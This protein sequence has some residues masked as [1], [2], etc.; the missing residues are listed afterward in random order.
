MELTDGTIKLRSPEEVDA[1]KVSAVVRSSLEDLFP[2]LPWATADY[3]VDE[4]G[5]WIRGEVDPTAQSFLIVEPDGAVVGAAALNMFDQYN[6][7]ANLG[8]WLATTATGQ[9][10]ATRVTRLLVAYG[11]ETLALH[12]VSTFMSVE[13][14]PSRRV[15]ERVGAVYEGVLRGHLQLHGRAHDVHSFSVVASDF[16]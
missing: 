13:N 14:E 1:A 6:K 4:A 11:I 5:A 15:A 12:R 8:Y 16:A 10:L 9:G 3:G 2:W 7:T